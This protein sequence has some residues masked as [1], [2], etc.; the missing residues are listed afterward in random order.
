M[1]VRTCVDTTSPT[2]RAPSRTYISGGTWPLP[3]HASAHRPH[4]AVLL[5]VAAGRRAS[6]ASVQQKPST[7]VFTRSATAAR[8]ERL[9]STYSPYSAVGSSVD[10]ALSPLSHR[11]YRMVRFVGPPAGYARYTY[12]SANAENGGPL[13]CLPSRLRA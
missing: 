2:M 9:P 12:A 4:S 10:T 11:S 13:G 7:H 6:L 5:R 1:G 3:G 8:T